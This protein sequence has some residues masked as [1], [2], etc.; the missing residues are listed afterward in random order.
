MLLDALIGPAKGHLLTRRNI[1]CRYVGGHFSP[2]GF[3]AAQEATVIVE[4]RI[5]SVG[6]TFV[7][8]AN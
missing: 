3:S 8:V 5:G 1:A 2:A 7:S 4:T 6:D